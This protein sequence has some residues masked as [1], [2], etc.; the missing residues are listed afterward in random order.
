MKIAIQTDNLRHLLE[1]VNSDCDCIRFGT[2]FCEYLLPE[3]ETL[4]ET[5]NAVIG[6]GKEFTYVTP[7]LS[8]SGIEKVRR[9][10]TFLNEKKNVG[11]VFNDL[12]T[13]NILKEY[14]NLLPRLGRLLVRVPARS[15]FTEKIAKLGVTITKA[16]GS[17]NDVTLGFGDTQVKEWYKEIFSYTSL[18]YSPTIEFYK[19]YGV[20]HADLDLIP[21]TFVRFDSL[22][23]QGLNLSIHLFLVPIAFTRK[24]HTARFLG[25]ERPEE[26]SKPCL[27]QAFMLSNK[28][29]GLVFFLQ[30]NAVFTFT[31]PDREDLKRLQEMNVAELVL[32]L[33]RVTGIDS[34]QNLAEIARIL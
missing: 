27:Q 7:R 26:C 15:P 34:K 19:S 18:N 14:G 20:R 11:V 21:R 1:A 28:P 10:L 33:N 3:Q 4:E 6:G 9:H 12:G 17:V 24:C 29:S 8:N 25:E 30:G 5:Y 22:M 32:T 13:L 16:H 31:Q 23:K 2:E